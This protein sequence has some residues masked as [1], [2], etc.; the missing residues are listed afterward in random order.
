MT[1]IANAQSQRRPSKKTRA[2]TSSTRDWG[3][4][5]I[6]NGRLVS[7]TLADP[8]VRE[9]LEAEWAE[10][11]KNPEALLQYYVKRGVLTPTGRLTKRYSR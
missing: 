1:S 9:E 7:K 3:Q 6:S 4:V 10:R 5:W 2:D 11:R 8:D